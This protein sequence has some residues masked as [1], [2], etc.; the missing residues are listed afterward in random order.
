[1]PT[2][3][4]PVCG[5][6]NQFPPDRAGQRATCPHCRWVIP[7]PKRGLGRTEIERQELRRLSTLP[8]SFAAPATY[9]LRPASEAS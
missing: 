5:A 7:V 8:V 3:I 1:M 4:C 9:R 6:C 2:T